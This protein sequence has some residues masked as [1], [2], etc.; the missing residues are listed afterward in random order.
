MNC[1]MNSAE[2]IL[3]DLRGQ[4]QCNGFNNSPTFSNHR[5]GR[6]PGW[7]GGPPTDLELGLSGAIMGCGNPS[8][9]G[10]AGGHFKVC[11]EHNSVSMQTAPPTAV[12]PEVFKVVC[13]KGFNDQGNFQNLRR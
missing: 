8:K 4:I 7:N 6:F 11:L 10:V 13:T 2:G 5:N 9:S 1:M 3:T 12:V